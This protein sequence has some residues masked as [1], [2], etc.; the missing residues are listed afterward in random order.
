M[1]LLRACLLIFLLCNLARRAKSIEN[2]FEVS[3]TDSL[4]LPWIMLLL[5]TVAGDERWQSTT[6]TVPA[7]PA[8]PGARTWVS[9][10][11]AW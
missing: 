8:A 2:D 1:R 11:Q 5:V 6:L 10:D 7:G 9:R 4:V 3:S